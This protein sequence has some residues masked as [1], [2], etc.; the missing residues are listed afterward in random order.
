M[1]GFSFF[2]ILRYSI[3]TRT[4]IRVLFRRSMNLERRKPPKV[5]FKIIF[6]SKKC[7]SF[8]FKP[9]NFEVHEKLLTEP[10]VLDPNMYKINIYER[11]NEFSNFWFSKNLHFPM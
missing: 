10:L 6:G 11:K 8:I 1:Y 4:P 7:F 3:Q 2:F 5:L 9:F